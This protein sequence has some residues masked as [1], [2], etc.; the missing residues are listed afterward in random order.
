MKLPRT[1][2]ELID[3]LDRAYPLKAYPVDMP[4]THIQR[5]MG[6]RDV[7]DFLRL[8]QKEREENFAEDL[9]SELFD[10]E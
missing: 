1:A 9:A 2:D 8:L 3:L 7:I 6:K 4:I 10:H 5:D